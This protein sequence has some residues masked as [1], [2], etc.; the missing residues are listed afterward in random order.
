ML[1]KSTLKATLMKTSTATLASNIDS[2]I[3]Q[4]AKYLGGRT[5]PS[6]SPVALKGLSID[7][8]NQSVGNVRLE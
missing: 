2:S 6:K 1:G 3:L 8:R 5:N 7:S 4:C